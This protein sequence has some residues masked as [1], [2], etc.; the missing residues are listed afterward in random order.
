MRGA[1]VVALLGLLLAPGA[2]S[3]APLVD[4]LIGVVDGRTV[5][6]SDVALA[7][8]LGVFG[9]HASTAPITHEDIERFADARLL[10]DEA[11]RIGIS[12]EPA[13]ID[14]AWTAVVARA[15][16]DGTLDRWLDAHAIDRAW[17]RRFVEQDVIRGRFFDARFAAFVFPDE[18]AVTAALGPGQHDETAR[19]AVR[20]RLI[21]EAADR[22]QAEWLQAARRAAT[23]KILLPPGATVPTPFPPP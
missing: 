4:A 19:E 18:A 2:P 7:R 3:A 21:R 13:E 1:V 14:R 6:A 17:A 12:A 11:G 8:A 23:I 16:A 10:L 22:A 20:A 15:G 9:F 5:S